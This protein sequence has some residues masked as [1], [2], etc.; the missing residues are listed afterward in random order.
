VTNYLR[1]RKRGRVS[2]RER[3]ELNKATRRLY[4][5][6]V[7]EDHPKYEAA[8]AKLGE[9]HAEAPPPLRTRRK[10]RGTPD[11]PLEKHILAAV[12]GALR[13]DPRVWICDRRQSG[14]FQDGDR[15]IRVG[16]RGHLDISGMLRGGAYFEIEVKRPGAKP[17][18]HQLE[19]IER[20]RAGGGISGYCWSVESAIALLPS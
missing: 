16:E 5:G 18:P 8:Q 15:Y 19:R 4:L 13:Y 14:V 9:L 12:M 10:A 2:L 11:R 20:V 3:L 1:S 7:P 6:A 17:E